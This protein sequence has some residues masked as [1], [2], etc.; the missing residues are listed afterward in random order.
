MPRRKSFT[1]P[2]ALL[3][4]PQY[5]RLNPLHK[6]LLLGLYAECD[7][8]GI[9]PA[10]KAGRRSEMD[11][12]GHEAVADALKKF[13][14]R[15]LIR[16]YIVDDEEFVRLVD[17]DQHL[18]SQQIARRLT[19]WPHQVNMDDNPNDSGELPKRKAVRVSRSVKQKGGKP[20]TTKK[21][22]D[23]K[24]LTNKRLGN[25]SK[26]RAK[27]EQEFEKFWVEYR[28]TAKSFGKGPGS[29]KEAFTWWARHNPPLA[30]VLEGLAKWAQSQDWADGFVRH[31][32]NWLKGELWK[33]DPSPAK[34]LKPHFQPTETKPVITEDEIPF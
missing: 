10:L 20:T 24:S 30:E 12:I 28:T 27:K 15:G 19:R 25:N 18:S 32:V 14:E 8:Y 6:G 23:T 31:A 26:T 33:D 7:D 1:V 4:R 5:S 9:L 16:I 3:E 29:R 11:L 17:Y 2:L 13:H 21:T 22:N 34:G